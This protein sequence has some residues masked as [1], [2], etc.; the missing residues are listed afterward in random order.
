[1]GID[2]KKVTTEVSG[3]ITEVY[4]EPSQ[5]YKIELYSIIVNT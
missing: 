2:T 5:T 3:N 4:S 1:M